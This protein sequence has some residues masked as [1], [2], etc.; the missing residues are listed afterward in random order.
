MTV[1]GVVQSPGVKVRE[2]ELT[3][4]S[5]VSLLL[6]LTVTFEEGAFSLTVNVEVVPSSDVWPEMLSMI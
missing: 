4:A 2:D 3:L 5:P 1:C 6:T